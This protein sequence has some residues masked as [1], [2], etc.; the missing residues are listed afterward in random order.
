MD[1][2][3]IDVEVI[4]GIINSYTRA[5]KNQ[6][7]IYGII[8]GTKKDTLYHITDVI[9][10]YIFEDGEDP[11]THKKNLTRLNDDCIKSL[12]N[13]LHQKFNL[14]SNSSNISSL[15][16]KGKEKQEKDNLFK[17]NDV[18]MILGGF[19]T[20]RE[21]FPDLHNLY[22]TIELIT[23]ATFKNINS[24]LLLVDPN[25]KD[26]KEIKY[27]VKTYN[28]SIKSI[29]MKNNYNRLLSFKELDNE[30]VQH[31]HN[32]EILNSINNKYLWEKIFNLNIDKNEKRNINELLFDLKDKEE[33]IL[34][35]ESNVEYIKNKIKEG[36]FY[37]DIFEKILENGDEKNKDSANIISDED[38]NKIA[39][40]L[41]QLESML[42]DKEI[43]DAINSDINKKYNIDSLSQ[44]LEVQL[45]LA[46]KIRQ[47]IN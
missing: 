18:Q 17:I 24:I 4:K 40:I 44:L 1:K 47:L 26:E 34:V 29:K 36:I 30:V 14:S 31:I 15:K 35:A 10:G 45:T 9:Y 7:R 16:V 37:L 46:D 41:S 43:I 39:Y 12:L 28:W 8:L 20:D 38:Y 22:S 19:A 13:S 3:L 6:S 27:G 2:V 23:D 42:N 33:N 32:V 25:Y 5:D 11:K 21:L